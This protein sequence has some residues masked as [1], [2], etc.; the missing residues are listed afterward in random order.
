[1]LP[2]KLLRSEQ[3]HHLPM[4]T[5]VVLTEPRLYPTGEKQTQENKIQDRSMFRT[6]LIIK[7][8]YINNQHCK[9]I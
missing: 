2:G 5:G 1:M 6:C 8:I 3:Q 7:L 4:E 9:H